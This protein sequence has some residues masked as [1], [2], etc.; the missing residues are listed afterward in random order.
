MLVAYISKST[1]ATGSEL[2]HLDHKINSAIKQLQGIK[3]R[4]DVNSIHKKIVKV[5]DFDS[6]S[7][8]FLND[9][10]EMLLQNDKTI[11]RLNR[12]KN[13]YRLNES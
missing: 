10:I 11:N 7:K 9:R 13:S 6:I 1:I 4:A 5:I 3:K 12:N 2:H 8:E